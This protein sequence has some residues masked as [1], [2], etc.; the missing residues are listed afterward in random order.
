M[1]KCCL[2]EYVDGEWIRHDG[3]LYGRGR[4]GVSASRPGLAQADPCGGR[5][6]RRG[7][8]LAADHIG[9]L[10]VL[11]G[12]ALPRLRVGRRPR[13]RVARVATGGAWP[14]ARP[15]GRDR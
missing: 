1:L 7:G 3:A 9:A 12:D 14:R 13:A 11:C 5:G 4:G 2:L 6:A 15:W 8:W 10:A